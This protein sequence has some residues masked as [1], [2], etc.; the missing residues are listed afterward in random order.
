MLH[1]ADVHPDKHSGLQANRNNNNNNNNNSGGD[2]GDQVQCGNQRHRSGSKEIEQQQQQQQQQ[3]GE[4]TRTVNGDPPDDEPDRGR[5]TPNKIHR[6]TLSFKDSIAAVGE[7]TLLQ[8]H[9]TGG[10]TIST[11]SSLYSIKSLPEVPNI[12]FMTPQHTGSSE[13]SYR[14]YYQTKKRPPPPV[15][16]H[17]QTPP[18]LP[19][20]SSNADPSARSH[21][22]SPISVASTS[23]IPQS[24]TSPLPS[25]NEPAYVH[26]IR[27]HLSQQARDVSH[28]RYADEFDLMETDRELDYETGDEDYPDFSDK[29]SSLFDL[30]LDQHSHST[31]QHHQTTEPATRIERIKRFFLSKRF[32]YAHQSWEFNI[33]FAVVVLL[34]AA[35]ATFMLLYI[36]NV[37]THLILKC[38]GIELITVLIPYLLFLMVGILVALQLVKNIMDK[39]NVTITIP[40]TS[41]TNA[42][43]EKLGLRGAVERRM[44]I[45]SGVYNHTVPSGRAHILEMEEFD[46]IFDADD[47]EMGDANGDDAIGHHRTLH[48]GALEETP[49]PTSSHRLHVN[50]GGSRNQP[51]SNSNYNFLNQSQHRS[52][53]REHMEE[54]QRM[55]KIREQRRKTMIK[56]IVYSIKTM[57]VVFGLVA[58][59]VL[60]AVSILLLI[61]TSSTLPNFGKTYTLN[62]LNSDV[63][64]ERESSGMVHIYAQTDRDMFFA[65]GFVAAQERLFQMELNKRIG[66]GTLAEMVGITGIE[67]DRF[68][69]TVG[70][71][72]AANRT[73]HAMSKRT[74]MIVHAFCDGVNAYIDTMPS[75]SPEFGV[76][77]ARPTRFYPVD[78]VTWIKLMSWTLST[79]G[80]RELR[81]YKLLERGLSIERVLELLPLYPIENATVVHAEDLGLQNMT[82]KEIS[83]VESKHTDHSGAF[84]PPVRMTTQKA[85]MDEAAHVDNLLSEQSQCQKH[86][87]WLAL[88][89]QKLWNIVSSL[90][91]LKE[92]PTSLAFVDQQVDHWMRRFLLN[93]DSFKASNNWVISGSSSKSGKPLLCNDP[94]LAFSSPMI[95]YLVH[96]HSAESGIDAIGAAFPNTPLVIVGR[97]QYISWG[98]TNAATDVQD[99]YVLHDNDGGDSYFYQ[100]KFRPYTLRNEV[101]NVFGDLPQ[102]IT[103]KESVFGPVMNDVVAKD[104]NRP[105]ALSWVSLNDD[106][107]TTM[108]AFSD[109][110]FAKNWEEFRDALRQYVAPSQ[111][112]VFADKDNNIGY[113]VPGRI[114]IR[115]QGHSGAFAVSGNGTFTYSGYVPFDELPQ[116]LNPS[117]GY[118]V[119][120]NNRI[121]PRGYKYN[122]GLDYD[123]PARAER[124]EEMIK[125]FINQT[126]HSLTLHEMRSIQI[127]TH[128]RVFA[129]LSFVFRDLEGHFND[130][131]S[132]DEYEKWRQRMVA[133]DGDENYFSREASVFETFL[134]QMGALAAVETGTESWKQIAYITNTLKYGDSVC[135]SYHKMTCMDYAAG[136]FRAAID[137]QKKRFGGVEQWGSI[138]R[139]E[140]PSTALD[141]TALQCIASR[142]INAGGGTHTVNVADIDSNFVTTSG[143]SYRQTIDMG[144]LGD[145]TPPEDRRAIRYDRF[146]MPMGMSENFYS[147]MFDNWLEKWKEGLYVDM[148]TSG[149][150]VET[151]Q[152]LASK[153]S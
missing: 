36:F 72:S 148:R 73:L 25:V 28:S 17:G 121:T 74:K 83:A 146:I 92:R 150:D 108:N 107:D 123:G 51:F 119:S 122:L 134:I 151:E 35:A 19:P 133:W 138:H 10:S 6:R 33:F 67:I 60:I 89:K 98:V 7:Q 58:W 34:F 136:A 126:D 30:S 65:Q 79:N 54:L 115:K 95:F 47:D 131:P 102:T 97:N 90:R 3:E 38:S 137:S 129:E 75:L 113:I 153:R 53:I 124:I 56:V 41:I 24:D 149:Y 9:N 106:S 87:P 93:E 55:E 59:A 141:K 21:S 94:H 77:V 80:N 139:I 88:L 132:Q 1:R 50:S 57:I 63:K 116:V 23:R 111:N 117:R 64:I 27:Q 135:M 12:A 5:M 62:A 32:R 40:I 49:T 70:F 43:V 145:Q 45:Q 52:K 81:R 4:E 37:H 78:V 110:M 143:P 127:D 99:Y 22:S 100:S 68:S 44:R 104:I 109:L 15:S 91:G 147:T 142:T 66:R 14:S 31:V 144:L 140:F 112:F 105:L 130:G 11:S 152:L 96:L 120:A 18:S 103:V 26:S 46:D 69:R 16:S 118:I 84:I 101:I 71:S 29:Q 125:T 82:E 85:T 13:R 76:L 61:I 48:I 2:G 128:S 20:V 114:P 42:T 8:K 86:N 39:H